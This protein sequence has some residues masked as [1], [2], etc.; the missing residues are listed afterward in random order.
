MSH[1]ITFA[2][3]KG[4]VS[5]TTSV[6]MFADILTQRGETVEVRDTDPSG[7][8]TK[9]KKM[10]AEAN[11]P[12]PFPVISCN[13]ANVGDPS[14]NNADWILIDTPPLQAEIIQA[15]INAADLVIVTV[16]PSRLDVDRAVT[17]VN[18]F[19]KDRTV[20]VTR[21]NK[22]AITWRQCEQALKDAGLPRLDAYIKAK[23]SIKRAVGTNIVP[24]DT[25]YDQAVDEV[26][27]YF[28]E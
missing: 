23:E 4:G 22:N 8:A 19:D 1:C 7:G 14:E 25:G 6:I 13:I 10:A 28:G 21:V 12:L 16:Q 2:N 18:A 15:A 24:A 9:W 27:Q 3:T 17:T 20:L 5:K 11:T 26:V